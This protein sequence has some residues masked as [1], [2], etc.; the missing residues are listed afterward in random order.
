MTTENKL[1]EISLQAVTTSTTRRQEVTDDHIRRAIEL[2]CANCY[3][4][5]SFANA[6]GGSKDVVWLLCHAFP[7]KDILVEADRRGIDLT[8]LKAAVDGTPV[9]ESMY[10]RRAAGV[11]TEDEFQKEFRQWQNSGRP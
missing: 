1:D 4:A 11:I 2:K 8:P 5:L 10:Y 7:L 3:G 9:K 6:L